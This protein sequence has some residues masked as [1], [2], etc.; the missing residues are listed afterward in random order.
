MTHAIPVVSQTQEAEVILSQIAELSQALET[1]NP[2]I[3]SYVKQIHKNLIQYPELVHILKPEQVATIV[4]GIETVT[5]EKIMEDAKP[6]PRA[7]SKSKESI[8]DLLEGFL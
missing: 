6:K 1:A 5:N 2:D 8:S 7:K 3:G 4:R